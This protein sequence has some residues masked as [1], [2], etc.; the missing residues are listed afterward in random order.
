MAQRFQARGLE[1]EFDDDWLVGVP[2]ASAFYR[3]HFIRMWDGIRAVDLLAVD[4]EGTLWLIEAKSFVEQ[5]RTDPEALDL[6]VGTKAFDTLAALLPA[7]RHANEAAD[8]TLARRALDARN[9][10]VVLHLEQPLHR[11]R[12]RPRAISP[13]DVKMALRRRIRPIDQHPL[14]VESTTRMPWRVSRI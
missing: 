5:P 1:F 6:V 10:R 3:R 14:V 12:L 4:P 11:S 7:K 8:V 9:L 13:A 2:D